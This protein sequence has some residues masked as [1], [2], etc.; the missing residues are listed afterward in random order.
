MSD[1][2]DRLVAIM[3]RL[4]DPGG[5][6][7]DR[8]QT[9][10]SLAGYLLEEAYEVVDAIAADDGARLRE[11]LGDLLLQIVFLARIARERGWFGIDDVSDAISGKMVRRHPHVFGDREVSGS[12]EVKQ[13]WEDIKTEER[14]AD[15]P[16][17]TLDGV[18]RSLPAL[19]KAFRMTEKAAAVGF[20]WRR[21]RDV[22]AKLHE[23][24]AELEAELDGLIAA[25]ADRVRAEMGDVLFVMANLARHL[26]VEPET[27]LQGTNAKFL[28]RFR[29]MEADARARG[30][31]LRELDLAE[32]DALWEAAKRAEADAG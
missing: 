21:P 7:W 3:D 17:S 28:R 22:M 15:H 4:R 32:Q 10:N 8:E 1:A 24:V 5:C 23:E 14:G 26:G 29:A 31:G 30:C 13:N 12:R 2:F 25:D 20:D 9:L 27:A 6:P 11:E 19:L 16:G 18:P